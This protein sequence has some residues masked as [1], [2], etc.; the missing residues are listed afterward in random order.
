MGTAPLRGQAAPASCPAAVLGLPA[1]GGALPHLA[2][3]AVRLRSCG[4]RGEA[5]VAG[6]AA[7]AAP[8]SQRRHLSPAS[9]LPPPLLGREGGRWAPRVA[10][11]WWRAGGGGPAV[12]A[13]S[14]ERRGRCVA[15]A[16][17]PAAWVGGGGEVVSGTAGAGGGGSRPRPWPAPGPAGCVSV[18]MAAPHSPAWAS[19][20]WVPR[21]D[22]PSAAA[23]HGRRGSC[24]VWAPLRAEPGSFSVPVSISVSAKRGQAAGAAVPLQRRAACWAVLGR[25]QK[26]L[27]CSGWLPFK[28]YL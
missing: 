5:A 6:G 11:G 18:P 24:C 19:R 16:G 13:W 23:G 21:L 7:S 8:S 20:C 4:R 25:G 9:L 27:I 28:S 3:V 12:R 2:G 15:Q 26:S 14:A 1:H 10:V 22:A 17:G